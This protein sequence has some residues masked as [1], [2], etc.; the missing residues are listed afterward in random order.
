MAHIFQGVDF[1]RCSRRIGLLYHNMAD[2]LML[3]FFDPF[4]SSIVR[5][6]GV[7]NV[8]SGIVAFP[9]SVMAL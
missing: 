4:V 6:R 1:V 8:L 9:V 2:L 5:R 7:V 3:Q